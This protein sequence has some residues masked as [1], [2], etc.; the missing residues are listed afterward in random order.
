MVHDLEVVDGLRG[1]LCAAAS[2]VLVVIAYTVDADCV[3]AWPQSSETKAP[4]RLGKRACRKRSSGWNG[5]WREGDKP[6][7]V[8]ILNAQL[9]HSIP[10]ELQ[11]IPYSGRSRTRS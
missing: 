1:E 10:A 2:G 9:R 7:E 11:H 5:L 4:A 8:S 6:Q 3:A